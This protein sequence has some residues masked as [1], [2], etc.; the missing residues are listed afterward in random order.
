MESAVGREVLEHLDPSGGPADTQ[1]LHPLGL[2]ETEV[3][4]PGLARE[5]SGPA[6]DLARLGA[7]AVPDRQLSA[8][9]AAIALYSTQ[10]DLQRVPL[11]SVIDE[12]RGGTTVILDDEVE[13]SVVVDVGDAE[14][15]RILVA[16]AA[17]DRADIDE[18]GVTQVAQQDIVLVPV[19]RLVADVD[20]R[21]DVAVDSGTS[22]DVLEKDRSQVIAVLARDETVQ[23]V[24]V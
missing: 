4:E 13:V 15:T 22:T 17:A 11:V 23:D 8:D 24:E 16:I 3:H 10:T 9:R 20:E 14:S 1:L 18:P 2:A 5:V 6:H 19:E 21:A 12:Q 7:L